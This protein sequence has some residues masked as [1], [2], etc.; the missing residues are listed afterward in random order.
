MVDLCA[1]GGPFAKDLWDISLWDL[2]YLNVKVH[3]IC[4]GPWFAMWTISK[5]F[6]G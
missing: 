4:A 5:G 6:V 2:V 1:V 3:Q